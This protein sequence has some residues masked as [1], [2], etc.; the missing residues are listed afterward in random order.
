MFDKTHSS[1]T[2]A[3]TFFCNQDNPMRYGIDAPGL[4][5][6]FF[7]A[8]FGLGI[9]ALGISLWGNGQGWTFWT[10]LTV[11]FLALYPVFMGCLM[12]FDS[13]HTKVRHADELLDL[14]AWTGAE[15]VLDVGCGRGMM[16][17]KAAQRLTTGTATGVDIWQAR[18]QAANSATAAL[19]NARVAGV[20]DK[21]SVQ[22]A[23]MRDLPFADASFDVVVS[24]WAVHNL[25]DPA[26]RLKT[27][28]QMVRVLRPGGTLVLSDIINR[29]EYLAQARN[30]NMRNIRLVLRSAARDRFLRAITFG[31]YQPAA[32]LAQHAG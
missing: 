10:G 16:L 27:I 4:V 5:A 21:V 26:D 32:V 11:G 2:L 13:L 14:I 24:G 19:E 23:D 12:L 1:P 9:F 22:T 6:S 28:A 29:A 20:A 18:D 17:V 7:A 30:L 25:P 31:S 3:Q 15:A 8:A